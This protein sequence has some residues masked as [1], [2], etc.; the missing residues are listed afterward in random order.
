[1]CTGQGNGL[2]ERIWDMMALVSQDTEACVISHI[3]YHLY[4]L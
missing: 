4:H 3:D 1:V 2:L